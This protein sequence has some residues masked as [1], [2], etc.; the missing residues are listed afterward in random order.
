MSG[1]VMDIRSLHGVNAS[2]RLVCGF[3]LSAES[4]QVLDDVDVAAESSYMKRW[5]PTFIS[6]RHISIARQQELHN[7]QISCKND[8]KA[9]GLRLK[10]FNM[11]F[12]PTRSN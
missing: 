1:S 3:Y 4:E 11:C 10:L 8:N 9:L 12:N 7:V 6:A 2:V 5:V